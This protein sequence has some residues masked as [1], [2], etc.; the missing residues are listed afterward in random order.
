MRNA[1]AAFERSKYR[2]LGRRAATLVSRYIVPTDINAPPTMSI[3]FA[4]TLF[5]HRSRSDHGPRI[6]VG[7]D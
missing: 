4:S 1:M 5:C 3:P 2:F 7:A 6:A